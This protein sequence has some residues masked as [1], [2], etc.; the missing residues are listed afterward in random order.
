MHVGTERVCAGIMRMHNLAQTVLF[1]CGRETIRTRL[2]PH[3]VKWYTGEANEDDED[4]DEEDDD[5]DDL[6]EDDEDDEVSVPTLFALNAVC[7]SVQ[8]VWMSIWC[9]FPGCC[10]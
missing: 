10:W 3:A 1:V 2:I 7:I 9:T 6:D 4:H 5:D 8:Q